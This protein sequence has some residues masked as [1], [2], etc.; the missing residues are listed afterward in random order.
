MISE[1][2]DLTTV[3]T[4]KQR[5]R[6]NEG[7]AKDLLNKGIRKDLPKHVL[8][9]QGCMVYLTGHE[10]IPISCSL[11]SREQSV[12][13]MVTS[14]KGYQILKVPPWFFYIL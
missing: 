6:E 10:I 14:S 11:R 4:P 1:A 2:T 7:S 13:K 12:G 5:V 3:R 9:K 8:M